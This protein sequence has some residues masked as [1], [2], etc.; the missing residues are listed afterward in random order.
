METSRD[1]SRPLTQN[2]AGLVDDDRFLGMR[3]TLRFA[4]SPNGYLHL[5]HAYSA[6]ANERA[7]RRLGA[8]LLLR[9]ENIDVERCRPEYERAIV[10]DLDWLGIAFEPEPRRQA[11]HFMAYRSALQL[12]CDRGLLYPCF[13]ARSDVARAV[14]G[15]R[16]WRRDPDGSPHY[17]GTCKHLSAPERERF[18]VSQPAALRIDVGKALAAVAGSLSWLEY[19]EGDAAIS[20]PADPARWGDAILA[21]RDI[22]ASYHIAVVVDDELQGV[23]DVVR[24]HDLYEAT[25]LHRLLQELLGYRQLRYRHHELL[26]D[27]DGD[28]LSKRNRAKSIRSMRAQGVTPADLRR[29]LGF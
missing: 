16:D 20:T 3:P 13:C 8:R 26:R 5:G 21:R 15:R 29:R 22:P 10:E 1:R 28:K 25:S 17:P 12:L 24:G 11:E 7:A 27:A 9:F 14:V 23:T 18:A 4:P 2:A 19:R 6:L